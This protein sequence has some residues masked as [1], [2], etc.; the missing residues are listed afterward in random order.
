VRVGSE[1]AVALRY[2]KMIRRAA[3]DSESARYLSEALG[4]PSA[5]WGIARRQ[6]EAE[7]GPVD[8]RLRFRAQRASLPAGF[9]PA[10]GLRGWRDS[11]VLKALEGQVSLQPDGLALR[12]FACKTSYQAMRDGVAVEG[13]VAVSL[14]VDEVGKT[15]AVVLPPSESLR[16]RQRTVLEE[17]ALL[18][19]IAASAAWGSKKD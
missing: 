10:Q 18:G 14:T 12:S 7:G 17:R 8:Y 15:A 3:Q 13:D 4:G 16:T 1:I 5:A 19:G 9:P 6:V 2:G 11:V